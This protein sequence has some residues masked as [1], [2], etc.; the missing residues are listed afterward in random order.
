M[1]KKIFILSKIF[2]KIF[3]LMPINKYEQSYTNNCR[4]FVL[5]FYL[6][7]PVAALGKFSKI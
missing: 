3:K 2:E 4:H 1:G 5:S 7:V 6:H